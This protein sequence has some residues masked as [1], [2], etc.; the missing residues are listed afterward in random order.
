MDFHMGQKSLAYIL[1][2]KAKR[3]NSGYGAIQ[4]NVIC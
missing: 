1:D 3:G 2:L 4:R